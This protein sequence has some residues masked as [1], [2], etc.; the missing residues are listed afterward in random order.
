MQGCDTLGV[1]EREKG[2]R[3]R[4]RYNL[5]RS[6]INLTQIDDYGCNWCKAASTRQMPR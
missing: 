5:H 3:D 2:C 1:G 4:G 6:E